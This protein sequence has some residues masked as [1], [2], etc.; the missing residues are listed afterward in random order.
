MPWTGLRVIAARQPC[1]PVG[2]RQARHL[3]WALRWPVPK[4]RPCLGVPTP[5]GTLFPQALSPRW[6]FRSAHGQRS[7]LQPV[8]LSTSPRTFVWMDSITNIIHPDKLRLLPHLLPAPGG[9]EHP[10]APP[11]P[12]RAGAIPVSW[13]FCPHPVPGAP[14]AVSMEQYQPRG[15]A[16][17]RGAHSHEAGAEPAGCAALTCL[18]SAAGAAGGA[19]GAASAAAGPGGRRGPRAGPAFIASAAAQQRPLR[20]RP[21]PALRPRPRG[22]P[23]CAPAPTAPAGTAVPPSCRSPAVPRSCRSSAGFPSQ[24]SAPVGFS[25]PVSALEARRWLLVGYR[26]GFGLGFFP[27]FLGVEEG[28]V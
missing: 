12:S 19:A 7:P 26:M 13:S 8:R 3:P 4:A 20:A 10:P 17:Q 1:A 27:F 25:F 16:G 5:A 2:C 21:R 9:Q 23:G 6:Q 18:N 22:H 11:R 14:G 28:N 15:D 24:V